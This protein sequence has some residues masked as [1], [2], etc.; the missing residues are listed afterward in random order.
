M[1]CGRFHQG[2]SLPETP[3][4]LMRSRYTAYTMANVDYIEQTMRGPAATGFSK[5]DARQWSSSVDWLGLEV[6]SARQEGDRG[7]VTF[8]ASFREHGQL[9]DIKECSLFER[10]DNKWYYVDRVTPQKVGRNESCPC[11]SGKKFKK[12]CAL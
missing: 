11:G 9:S 8:I 5:E 3:E 4:Q 12:C 7:W 6:R 1:C 2:D 10:V